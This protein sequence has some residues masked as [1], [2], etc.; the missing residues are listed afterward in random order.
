MAVID[1][2]TT[3]LAPWSEDE[4]IP[5]LGQVSFTLTTAPTD[6]ASFELHVNGLA[7]DDVDDYILSGQ[8]LTWL[9]ALFALAPGDKLLARYV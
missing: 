6:T 9:N 2:T 7:Y 1:V 8:T 4:F 5:T 3:A